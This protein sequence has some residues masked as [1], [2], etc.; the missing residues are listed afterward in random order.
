MLSK[1]CRY[2]IPNYAAKYVVL[3]TRLSIPHQKTFRIH[4]ISN[5]FFIDTFIFAAYFKLLKL[6]REHHCGEEANP[7]V[8]TSALR[9]LRQAYACSLSGTFRQT[10]ALLCLSG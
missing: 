5:S 10:G 4:T 9:A 8:R 2:C 1:I 7:E 3:F 6:L